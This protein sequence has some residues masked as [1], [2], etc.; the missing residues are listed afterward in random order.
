MSAPL[1]FT[2]LG[3]GVAGM[4]AALTLR[5]RDADRR[6]ALISE[7]HDHFFAR[8]ALIYVSSGQLGLPDIEPYDR[9]LYERMGFERLRKRVVA[10]DAAS[11]VLV[12][13]DGERLE[14]D[15]LLLAVGS[16][17]RPA[18]WPGS[19]GPGLHTFVTPR[20]LG[21]LDRA[22]RR[23]MRA[24]V[25]GGGLIGAE[26]AEI[27]LHRGLH[28][29]FVVRES[30]YFPVALERNEA[31]LVA[32][33]IRSHG[34]PVRLGARVDEILRGSDGRLIAVRVGGED[35]P[36]DIVVAA[37]GVIPNTDF[38]SGSGVAL[39]PGGAV[40]VDEELR[41]NVPG[42]WAAGDCANVRWADGSRRPEQLYLEQEDGARWYSC[43]DQGRVAAAGMLGD[44][45]SY[46]RGTWYNS[47]KFFDIEYTSAG[48]LP[49]LVDW[50]GTPREPGPGVRT[51]FQRVPGDCRSQRIVLTDG[52]VVGFS[53]LGSRWNP[54]LLTRW[55]DERRELPWVLSHLAEAQ[56]DEEL[57]PA[58][59]VLPT[60]ELT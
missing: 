47:A 18:P 32:E 46:Q 12:F 26:V 20:D 23:G 38:L 2:V 36:C 3:N 55:I 24:V 37:V 10:L 58:F 44:Q 42:V 6:I 27:L 43:R 17:A 56:L 19:A 57:S 8:P 29:T 16:R 1:H 35:V 15:R 14:F 40:E 33:H 25:I 53:M 51:W 22:S 7:E 9:Q 59:C 60:S 49:V 52:R 41:T 11:R 34:C 4:E 30:W 45:T 48:A 13:Q 50:D 5:G 39:S 21:R 31:T 28:V 54:R